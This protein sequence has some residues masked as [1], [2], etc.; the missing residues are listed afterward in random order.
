MVSKVKAR[1]KVMGAESIA[2]CTRTHLQVSCVNRQERRSGFG[3]EGGRGVVGLDESGV[4][5]VG[6]GIQLQPRSQRLQV[7]FVV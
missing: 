7:L 5:V 4:V 3:Q 6:G 2:Y 1:E